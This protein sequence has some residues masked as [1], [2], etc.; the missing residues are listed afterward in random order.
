MKFATE[1]A[2]VI[3]KTDYLI[4]PALTKAVSNY[5]TLLGKVCTFICYQYPSKKDQI[6]SPLDSVSL[7]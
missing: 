7:P 2:I 3:H 4:I 5:Y 6:C 1:Y